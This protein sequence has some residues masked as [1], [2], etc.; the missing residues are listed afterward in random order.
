MPPD[1]GSDGVDTAAPMDDVSADPADAAPDAS[2]GP[3]R[4]AAPHDDA[5]TLEV[6]SIETIPQT[7]MP[8]SSILFE[9]IVTDALGADNI[10]S[11][12]L[13]DDTGAIYT[14]LMSTGG[15]SVNVTLAWSDL[16]RARSID[17]GPQGTT[18]DFIARFKNRQ[19]FSASQSVNIALTCPSQQQSCL[20]GVCRPAQ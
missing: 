6:V 17:F 14:S 2:V 20:R 10:V 19:G 9:V 13:T 1:A 5:S 18:R 16:Q 3:T 7:L 15:F 12:D 8:G 11:G 4:D